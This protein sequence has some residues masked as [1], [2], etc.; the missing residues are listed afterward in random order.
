M[1]KSWLKSIWEKVQ[2]FHLRIEIDNIYLVPPREGDAWFMEELFWMQFDKDEL[3]RLN[4]V[5]LHQQVI[6]CRIS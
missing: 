4:R 1:T 5:R 6:F 3:M 2:A